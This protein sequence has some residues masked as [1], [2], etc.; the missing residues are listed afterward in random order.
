MAISKVSFDELIVE[1]T[2]T[3]SQEKNVRVI[4]NTYL[5]TAAYKA[6]EHS[7]RAIDVP[8]IYQLAGHA[9]YWTN[10][11]KPFRFETASQTFS[12]VKR[13]LKNA[14]SYIVKTKS[15]QIEEPKDFDFGLNEYLSFHIAVGVVLSLQ[16][17]KVNGQNG[18]SSYSVE[19]KE[20]YEQQASH[21]QERIEMMEQPVLSYLKLTCSSEHDLSVLIETLMRTKIV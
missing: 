19:Q 2:D 17:G 8:S 20:A 9:A 10:R 15:A 11:F 14:G 5:T 4:T 18:Q 7:L 1:L 3:I 12:A 6:S 13:S 21:I 16:E